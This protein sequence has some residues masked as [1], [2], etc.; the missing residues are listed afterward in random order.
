MILVFTILLAAESSVTFFWP[1]V[2]RKAMRGELT[3]SRAES[4]GCWDHGQG[5]A[6]VH[7]AQ[8]MLHVRAD[9]RVRRAEGWVAGRQ[10]GGWKTDQG[11]IGDDGAAGQT[12]RARWEEGE[13]RV[14]TDSD[15]CFQAGHKSNVKGTK[16]I[17]HQI[18]T[19]SIEADQ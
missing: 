19:W 3:V 7:R 16:D 12:C 9:V 15:R 13:E 2:E 4:S 10:G 11:D 1:F 14:V 18:K 5:G 6:A 8:V 17:Y